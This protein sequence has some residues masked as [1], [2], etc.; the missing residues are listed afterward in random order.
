MDIIL[1]FHKFVRII[2]RLILFH[3]M[4]EDNVL[5]FHVNGNDDDVLKVEHKVRKLAQGG[6]FIC[7]RGEA[8]IKLDDMPLLIT[9]NSMVVYFPYSTLEITYRSNDLSGIIMAIELD[10]V[11]PLVAKISDINSVLHIRQNPLVKLSE[12]DR[13]RIFEYIKLYERHLQLSKLFAVNNHRRFWQLNN[14][15]LDNVKTNLILQIF[16]VYTPKDTSPK[17]AVNRKDEIVR[18]FLI[19]LQRNYIVQHEVGFYSNLQ[20]ISMRYFSFVIK[21]RTGK[22]PSQW[23]AASLCNDAKHMLTDTNLTIKEIAD[24][25]K[26]PNQSYFG[27]WFKANVGIG[28]MDFKKKNIGI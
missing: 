24:Q 10:G 15:Q 3:A 14:I 4:T 11:L 13:L 9:K 16:L 18:N 28:P 17:N 20:C 7:N 6:M 25:L 22:T 8:T 23:I 19:D 2:L 26:F 12:E 21:D 1:F 27:K 5:Y